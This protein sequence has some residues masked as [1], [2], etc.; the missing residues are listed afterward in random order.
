MKDKTIELHEQ[1]DGLST[2]ATL[3]AEKVNTIES[4]VRDLIEH[5]A[6]L[7]RR[8]QDTPLTALET[9]RVLEASL[10]QCN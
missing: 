3:V 4:K 8:L 7:V 6:H 9:E 5:P 1:V 10:H 2:S